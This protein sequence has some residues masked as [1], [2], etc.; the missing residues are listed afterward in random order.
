MQHSF[1]WCMQLQVY[2]VRPY[3]P[4]FLVVFILRRVRGAAKNSDAI[5]KMA[6]KKSNRMAHS[7]QIQISLG[8][9]VK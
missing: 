3:R 7:A 8:S 9:T 6:K 2:T 4:D 1:R 5:L